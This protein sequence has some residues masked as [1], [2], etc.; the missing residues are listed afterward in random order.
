MFV[1][2][3]ILQFFFQIS[4]LPADL[5]LW[6]GVDL[7]TTDRHIQRAPE[8]NN[9]LDQARERIR[10]LQ[11]SAAQTAAQNAAQNAV[12]EAAQAA[13][14]LRLEDAEKRLAAQQ[15]ENVHNKTRLF[16]A[17]ESSA[18]QLAQIEHYQKRIDELETVERNRTREESRQQLDLAEKL[19][20]SRQTIET[21]KRTIADH[22]S[23]REMQVVLAKQ[24]QDQQ[25]MTNKLEKCCMVITEFKRRILEYKSESNRQ[26]LAAE[27][28]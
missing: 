4:A 22:E 23:A 10:A 26:V 6:R 21:L 19:S 8:Q 5:S 20:Q 15:E 25:G 27:L 7:E 9:G 11:N 18:G 14:T 3:S 24:H 16:E 13:I 2:R 28:L 17:R 1:K 12:H